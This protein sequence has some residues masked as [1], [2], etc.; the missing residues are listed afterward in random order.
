MFMMS[1]GGLT[2]AE[3]FQGKDAIL[4][5][6]AGGVVGLAK[7]GRRRP[8]SSRDHRF[9]HGRHVDRRSPL[10]RRVSSAPSRREVAGVRMRAPMMLDPHRRRR[11]RLDPAFRRTRFRVGPDSAGADPG[12]AC[13]SPRRPADGHR[14]QCHDRQAHAGTLPGDLRPEPDQPLDATRPCARKF[15]ELAAETGDGRTPGGRS[16]TASSRSPSPIWRT[17]S[18]RFPCSAATT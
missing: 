8:A 7:T 17:R 10:R 18:R 15:A 3:L 11:R 2:A 5:G 4:S 6:P 9:R 1:S 14:R 12:P 16:P 13:L